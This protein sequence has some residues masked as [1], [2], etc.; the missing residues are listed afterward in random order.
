MLTRERRQKDQS[1]KKTTECQVTG[2]SFLVS[3]IHFYFSQFS[4]L[5]DLQKLHLTPTTASSYSSSSCSQK[6]LQIFYPQKYIFISSAS[7]WTFS[8]LKPLSSQLVLK[9]NFTRRAGAE[10]DVLWIKNLVQN[11]TVFLLPHSKPST[12]YDM[13]WISKVVALCIHNWI[14]HKKATEN[15]E[16]IS[17]R[18]THW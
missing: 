6:L 11:K 8:P 2:S 17:M 18:L 7:A 1:K 14:I 4:R 10:G 16:R 5:S 9:W 13:S 12:E 3:R 15:F